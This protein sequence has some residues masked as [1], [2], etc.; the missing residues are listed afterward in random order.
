M[1][2]AVVETNQIL[3]PLPWRGG[4]VISRESDNVFLL[5][6]ALA[7]HSATASSAEARSGVHVLK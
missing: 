1:Y 5:W 7:S 6:T 3:G 2:S 4:A